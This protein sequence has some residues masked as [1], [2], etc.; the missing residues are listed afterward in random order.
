MSMWTVRLHQSR[1][2]GARNPKR[3]WVVD[4]PGYDYKRRAEHT[5]NWHRA[6]GKYFQWG[7]NVSKR[8][9]WRE[10]MDY[11]DRMSRTRGVMLPRLVECGG[12]VPG[13]P[14][15]RFGVE[16]ESGVQ[17]GVPLFWLS[18]WG[19]DYVYIRLDELRPLAAVLLSIAEKEEHK[20]DTH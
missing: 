9:A 10:A 8:E 5:G 12:R 7:G 19:S 6:G 2:N 15:L 13:A 16:Y 3:R 1:R 11:A 17:D 18:D 4:P 20:N 14:G